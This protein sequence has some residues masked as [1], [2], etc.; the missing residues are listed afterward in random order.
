MEGRT[1]ALVRRAASLAAQIPSS[2][3][4]VFDTEFLD[5]GNVVVDFDVPWVAGSVPAVPL[6][7]VAML[8]TNVGPALFDTG[9]SPVT[10]VARSVI[11][12]LGARYG[13]VAPCTPLELGGTGVGSCVHGTLRSSATF[14]ITV[15]Y[16]FLEKGMAERGLPPF[17]QEV[18]AVLS[19]YVVEDAQLVA[20]Q[21]SHSVPPLLLLGSDALSDWARRWGYPLV[22][23]SD[24]GPAFASA[25]FEK[26]AAGHGALPD[27]GTPRHP[28]G[29]GQVEALVGR[30]KRA[31]K[32]LLPQGQLETWPSAIAEIEVGYMQ[33]PQIGMGGYSPFEYLVARPPRHFDALFGGGTRRS[34]GRTCC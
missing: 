15:Q 7:E 13:T 4:L 34:A 8:H 27:I 29:R 22:I 20:L 2:G 16:S 18:G 26:F 5:V 9:G 1:F 3:S 11:D 17:A 14:M 30:V 32:S 12:S 6:G 33:S 23:H 21:G 28:R 25:E 31:L 24:G 19:A 10:L